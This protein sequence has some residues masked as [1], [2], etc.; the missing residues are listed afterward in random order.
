M[1]KLSRRKNFWTTITRGSLLLITNS[2]LLYLK[3]LDV[4]IIEGLFFNS[5]L[6]K[7]G[8]AL[9]IYTHVRVFA[10]EFVWAMVQYDILY[11]RYQPNPAML[12]IKVPV[13]R[14][15][16]CRGMRGK[17]ME[18][19][20]CS[21]RPLIKA[22]GIRRTKMK[23]EGSKSRRIVSRIMSCNGWGIG[24]IKIKTSKSTKYLYKTGSR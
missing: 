9:N 15:G 19:G 14:G 5:R 13:K 6:V 3:N 20:C 22:A 12:K 11:K 16:T 17:E 24:T 8:N 23:V 4:M 18:R 7:V 10:F 1:H 2:R 21:Q